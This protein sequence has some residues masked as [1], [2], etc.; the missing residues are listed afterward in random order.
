VISRDILLGCVMA[1]IGASAAAQQ[2][3]LIVYPNK[4]QDN[5]QQEQDKFACYGWAKEQ[6]GFDPMAPPVTTTPPPQQEAKRGGLLSGA[7]RGAIIGGII[8]GKDGAKTGAGAGA[9]IGGM[10]RM[11][12]NRSEA[13]QRQQW[14]QQ[15]ASMYQ[16]NRNSY[17]RAYSA[18]M[19]GR[20]Y[21]VR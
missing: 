1:M 15:Q 9:A 14:E 19:E 11:D 13:Q 16:N 8:D 18:C 21:T 4:G 3:E 12:Q 17:N 6:S 5:A 2:P 10:R 20:G 7:V